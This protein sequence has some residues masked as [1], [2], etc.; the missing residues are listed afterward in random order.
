MII[1]L[2]KRGCLHSST[3]PQQKSELAVALMSSKSIEEIAT[4]RGVKIPTLRT[5]F[6][7]CLPRLAPKSQRHLVRLLGTIPQMEDEG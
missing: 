7:V 1:D 4:E 5:R 2:A 3:S 6:E